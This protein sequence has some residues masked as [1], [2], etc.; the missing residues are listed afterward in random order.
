MR[1]GC[2]GGG[3]EDLANEGS[4]GFPAVFR[5]LEPESL[6]DR[7]P[8]V[9][10]SA[11]PLLFS[12][13]PRPHRV[14]RPSRDPRASH[15]RPSAQARAA[16]HLLAPGA[17]R[18]PGGTRVPARPRGPGCGGSRSGRRRR[19]PRAPPRPGPAPPRPTLRPSPPLSR[20][21]PPSAAAGSALGPART[22]PVSAAPRPGRLCRLPPRGRHHPAPWRSF[23]GD[24]RAV[25]RSLF[26]RAGRDGS[27]V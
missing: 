2:L 11:L 10:E 17:G 16:S 24:S 3:Q 27:R 18:P 20:A 7:H 6:T 5:S 15:C 25:H 14:C 13:R 12:P 4:S 9:T 21:L 8:A 22:P 23:R 1:D 26:P 19:G